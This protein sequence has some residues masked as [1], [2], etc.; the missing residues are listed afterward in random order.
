MHLKRPEA[1][2][3]PDLAGCPLFLMD[4]SKGSV[5]PMLL[6]VDTVPSGAQA[7]VENGMS[8][9]TPCQL[10]VTPMG[11]F[12]VDFTLKN[13]EPQ[14]VEVVLAPLNPLWISRE[15]SVARVPVRRPGK[16]RLQNH[17]RRN[18]CGQKRPRRSRLRVVEHLLIPDIIA[19]PRGKRRARNPE[20]LSSAETTSVAVQKSAS[21][22]PRV[23][24]ADF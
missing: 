21:F 1:G 13:Y 10:T 24:D 7:Q 14:S 6:V 20:P 17:R 9:Q 18:P 8:C 12:K 5:A 2:P 15:V 11:T 16:S 4:A 22:F 3:N 19:A 23:R